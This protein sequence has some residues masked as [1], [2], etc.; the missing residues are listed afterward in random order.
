[1]HTL[2][3]TIGVAGREPCQKIVDAYYGTQRRSGEYRSCS[4][5]DYRL[6]EDQL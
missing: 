4:A 6:Y 3:V 5:Y 2:R 1:M